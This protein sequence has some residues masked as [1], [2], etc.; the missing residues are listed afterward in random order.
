MKSSVKLLFAGLAAMLVFSGRF[1][2]AGSGIS[3]SNDWVE[4]HE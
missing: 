4:T 2:G 1:L 3:I